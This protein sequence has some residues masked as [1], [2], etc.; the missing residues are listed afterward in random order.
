MYMQLVFP[1]I[2]TIKISSA[3][4]AEM[5]KNAIEKA[6][7]DPLPILAQTRCSPLNLYTLAHH[8]SNHHAI[9]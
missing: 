7:N 4:E 9:D 2:N 3:Q 8:I 1:F 5:L 6:N